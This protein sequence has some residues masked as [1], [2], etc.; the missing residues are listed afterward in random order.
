AHKAQERKRG[1]RPSGRHRRSLPGPGLRGGGRR[2]EGCWP[3][4]TEHRGPGTLPAARARPRRLAWLY[5]VPGRSAF[6]AA[7]QAPLASGGLRARAR[8]RGSGAGSLGGPPRPPPRVL[9]AAGPLERENGSCQRPRRA[10]LL[11]SAAGASPGAPFIPRPQRL[12]LGLAPPR[13]LRC[14]PSGS[15]PCLRPE[16]ADGA[17]GFARLASA[18]PL[19]GA[20]RQRARGR[21]GGRQRRGTPS[22][23]KTKRRKG[24]AAAR[25]PG[26]GSGRGGANGRA[27][28][29]GRRGRRRDKALAAA[30]AQGP[31]AT[32][33]ARSRALLAPAASP[34]DRPPPLGTGRGPETKGGGGSSTVQRSKSFSLRA[35]VKETCTA[36]QKTVYPME[37]L[38]ADKLIFHNSCF[39]C[40]HCHTKLSLGSYA[41]L[42]GEFYCKPHFQQL[43]KSK[44]NYDEGFGRKQHKELWAHKEVDSG[45]KTA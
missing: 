16:R 15:G 2:L 44:G 25:G 11:F 5:R 20:E 39:C 33:A 43:F 18:K 21:R 6:L 7:A 13:G 42:H 38:V 30:A 45:T 12:H 34:G 19:G 26:G 29:G 28:G 40:K 3:K 1:G 22:E 35:Q 24:S 37:R 32:A 41:A 4:E 8:G 36:C 9:R 31:L 10:W 23:G 14:G 17:A 27:R